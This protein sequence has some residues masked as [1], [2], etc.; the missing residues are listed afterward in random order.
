MEMLLVLI[1]GVALGAVIAMPTGCRRGLRNP[2]PPPNGRP[3]PPPRPSAPPFGFY[4]WPHA[5]LKCAVE[6]CASN[7]MDRSNFCGPHGGQP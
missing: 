3:K 5:P 1:Y 6:G 4:R 2:P 7:A